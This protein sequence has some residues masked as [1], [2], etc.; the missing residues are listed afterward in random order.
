[1][2]SDIRVLGLMKYA[3]TQSTLQFFTKYSN[4]QK[5]MEKEEKKKWEKQKVGIKVQKNKN[6]KIRRAELKYV[7]HSSIKSSVSKCDVTSCATLLVL[8]N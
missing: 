7:P 5:R 6:N 1:M 3:K 4:L 2:R 8:S